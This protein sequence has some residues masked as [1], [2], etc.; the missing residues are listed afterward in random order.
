[1]KN[2]KRKFTITLALST[3]A[4]VVLIPV[5]IAQGY[6]YWSELGELFSDTYGEAKVYLDSLITET[7]GE[8]APVIQ[9]AVNEALGVLE[10]TDPLIVEEQIKEGVLNSDKEFDLSKPPAV[11]QASSI[12]KEVDRQRL[13][14]HVASVIGQEG[15]AAIQTKMEQISITLEETQELGYAAEDAIST[16]EAI[17]KIAQ[18]NVKNTELLGALQTEVINSRI[19]TQFEAEVLGNISQTLDEERTVRQNLELAGVATALSLAAQSTLF[20]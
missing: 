9:S 5:Q 7:F 10:I 2:M 20:E 18:Q 3:S 19:D 1:M 4:F 12:G 13:R 17:K 15:Q 16:Q 6:S 8:D 11:V 14:S